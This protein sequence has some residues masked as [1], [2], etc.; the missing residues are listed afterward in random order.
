[1]P[2]LFYLTQF[3]LRLLNKFYFTSGKNDSEFSHMSPNPLAEVC[4]SCSKAAGRINKS[5]P[6][7]FRKAAC[8][9]HAALK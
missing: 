2:K 3:I 1:M 7:G 8:S 6:E 5:S 4:N 9:S